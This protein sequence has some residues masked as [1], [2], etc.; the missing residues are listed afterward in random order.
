[1]S[2]QRLDEALEAYLAA[3][4][5]LILAT[6]ERV[7]EQLPAETSQ[8]IVQ[9]VDDVDSSRLWF[10]QALDADGE[11]LVGESTDTGDV[12]DDVDQLVSGLADDWDS[13]DSRYLRTQNRLGI[14]DGMWFVLSRDALRAPV[15]TLAQ[16]QPESAAA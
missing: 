13:A 15:T 11:V 6:E 7:W 10:E 12:Y 3:R 16:D 2:Q 1:M 14:D 4:E 5:E 8:V 9:W